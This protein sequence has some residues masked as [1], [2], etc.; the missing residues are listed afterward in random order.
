M[1]DPVRHMYPSTAEEDTVE[2]LVEVDPRGGEKDIRDLVLEKEGGAVEAA[3]HIVGE[4]ILGHALGRENLDDQYLTLEVVRIL[5]HLG[6]V[7]IH[8]HQNI[9][10][11]RETHQV[12]QAG[13]HDHLPKS[14]HVP[15]HP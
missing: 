15:N 3:H 7:Q 11:R 2:G 14:N 10:Q 13:S 12:I 1:D 4:V 6:Q 8:L 9:D 5:D